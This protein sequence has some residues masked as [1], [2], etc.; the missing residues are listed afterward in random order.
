MFVI[1]NTNH[2]NNHVRF[3]FVI[4]EITDKTES[5]LDILIMRHVENKGDSS[6][7]AFIKDTLAIT[8]QKGSIIDEDNGALLE[9]LAII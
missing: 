6:P 1:T 8:V 2:L 7:Y 4:G 9:K 5:A 3:D